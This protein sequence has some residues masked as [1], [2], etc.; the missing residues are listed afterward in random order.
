MD[1]RSTE[2]GVEIVTKPGTI[3]GLVGLTSGTA[4]GDF[5]KGRGTGLHGKI[6][7]Y[8]ADVAER[9]TFVNQVFLGGAC[10]PTTWRKDTAIP[11]LEEAGCAY[12]NPQVE[13]WDE[14]CIAKE[15]K[16]KAES[17]ILLFVFDAETRGIATIN[18]VVENIA[19][20]RE[21]VLVRGLVKAGQDVGGQRLSAE[22]AMDINMARGELFGWASALGVEVFP[23]VEGAIHGCV[24]LMKEA[25]TD[26]VIPDAM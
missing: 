4:E 5:E 20:G 25:G 19:A 7:A 2:I 9:S 12:F 23:T 16:A 21:V 26:S 6:W 11:M 17:Y 15:A 22:E 3:N 10:D 24:E 1:P 13:E 8:L 14:S 18:E